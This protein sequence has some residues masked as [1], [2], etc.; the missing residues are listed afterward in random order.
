MNE[1][2][3]CFVTPNPIPG[4]N[5]AFQLTNHTIMAPDPR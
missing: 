5:I 1:I 4:N 3:V 2:I